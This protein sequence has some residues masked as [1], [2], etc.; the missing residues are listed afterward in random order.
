VRRAVAALGARLLR[1][2]CVGAIAASIGDLML[3]YVGNAQRPDLHLAAPPPAVLWIGAALGVVGIPLY[4][5]GYVGLRARFVASARSTAN[6][7]AAAGIIACLTGAVVHALTALAIDASLGAN[8]QSQG[9]LEAVAGTRGALGTSWL[10]CGIAFVVASAVFMHLQARYAVGSTRWL[11]VVNPVAVTIG[12]IAL[13]LPF[14]W[15]R[16][17]V[18][19]AAPNLSHV[20]FFLLFSTARLAVA[21]EVE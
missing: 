18:A 2:A 16:S 12:L 6:V 15:G 9:P 10:L 5:L 3:L 17:F 11:A 1:I 14:E 7:F 19:P 8:A 13:S 20:A 21:T 4:G